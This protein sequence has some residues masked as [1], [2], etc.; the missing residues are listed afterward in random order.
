MLEAA[1][2]IMLAARNGSKGKGVDIIEI[3]TLSDEEHRCRIGRVAPAR[4][5]N[6]Q[7]PYPGQRKHTKRRRHDCRRMTS[8]APQRS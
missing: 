7:V 8:Q 2:Q 3:I 4:R 6:R 1:K 5:K